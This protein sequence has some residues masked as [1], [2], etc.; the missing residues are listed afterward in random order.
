MNHDN[1]AQEMNAYIDRLE[2][3][4]FQ[5][6]L[7]MDAWI[8]NWMFHEDLIEDYSTL[9]ILNFLILQ[10]KFLQIL[11]NRKNVGSVDGRNFNANWTPAPRDTRKNSVNRLGIY[12][13]R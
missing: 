4:N 6:M 3:S 11:S 8:H 9:S 2:A 13:K 10:N 12:F 5:S 1:L 7:H